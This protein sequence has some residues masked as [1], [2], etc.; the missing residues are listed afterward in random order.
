MMFD[1]DTISEYEN[2]RELRNLVMHHN[3]VVVGNA[4]SWS[5]A[6][7]NKDN[8][9]KYIKSLLNSLPIDYQKGFISDINKLICDV[10]ELKINLE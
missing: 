4:I 3:L 10:I 8:L 7:C 1:K 5:G 2:I 9:A 6:L